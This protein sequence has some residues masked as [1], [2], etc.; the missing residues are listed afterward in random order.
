MAFG[1]VRKSYSDWS[2]ALG[3]SVGWEG[4]VPSSHSTVRRARATNSF[5]V[6]RRE[7]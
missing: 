4:S 2:W 1:G 3:V 7:T 6:G 5:R